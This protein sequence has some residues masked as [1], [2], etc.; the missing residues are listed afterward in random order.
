MAMRR[1]TLN[2]RKRKAKNRSYAT[3]DGVD[4]ANAIM[5]WE[6]AREQG[7]CAICGRRGRNWQAHHVIERQYLRSH[8]LA[9]FDQRNSLR[10]CEEPC[11][12]QHTRGFKR[13]PLTALTD[14]NLEYAFHILGDYAP[15]YLR[16]RYDGE[17]E[18][19][20]RLAA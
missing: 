19:V 15:Y 5:F 13:M 18:R 9:Q 11:H 6:A 1:T 20:E 14:E 10:V 2:Q 16:Q 7:R 4:D 12:G 3:A 17:D 8:F